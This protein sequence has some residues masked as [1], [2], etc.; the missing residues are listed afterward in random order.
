VVQRSQTYKWIIFHPRVAG[1]NQ[2]LAA[3]L[4]DLVDLTERD[5]EVE[6]DGEAFSI[7][8]LFA[9]L[10]P[11][12]NYLAPSES[13]FAPTLGVVLG[14]V[15]QVRGDRLFELEELWPRLN[16]GSQTLGTVHAELRREVQASVDDTV[17]ANAL[18]RACLLARAIVRSGRFSASDELRTRLERFISHCHASL[19]RRKNFLPLWKTVEEFSGIVERLVATGLV[20]AVEAAY[21]EARTR[22][23]GNGDL[24][25]SFR[26]EQD[27]LIGRLRSP[28][29]QMA[30][31][32]GVFTMLLKTMA[33]RDLL[34][35]HLQTFRGSF[36]GVPGFWEVAYT[37]FEPIR[38]RGSL[39]VLYRRDEARPLLETSPMV[40]SL[41][42]VEEQRSRIFVYFFLLEEQTFKH[43]DTVQVREHRE[44]L[45]GEFIEQFPAF[46]QAHLA[47]VVI[48]D[49]AAA[50]SRR[51][52]GT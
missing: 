27:R 16:L 45:V 32:N 43:W 42:E 35:K 21:A 40:R 13:E 20:E 46:V 34:A 26:H 36:F 39:A 28:R 15:V 1:S 22:L 50:H 9:P 52:E 24:L 12:M 51:P 47:D 5:D 44:D 30:G 19:Y 38:T 4:H 18:K 6:I 23:E 17:V 33:Y 37:G 10:R 48:E 49:L 31:V 2:A 14:S 8:R 41:T 29:T 7:R 3:A 25:E 11:N